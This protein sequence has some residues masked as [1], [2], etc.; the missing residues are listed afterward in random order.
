VDYPGIPE[1]DRSKKNSVTKNVK[2][3]KEAPS[4]QPS[5]S[6]QSSVDPRSHLAYPLSYIRVSYHVPFECL[7]LNNVETD[8]R[9]AGFPSDEESLRLLRV[10]VAS[11]HSAMDPAYHAF[12]TELSDI[13][14]YGMPVVR[15]AIQAVLFLD[16]SLEDGPRGANV[17]NIEVRD[18]TRYLGSK[19]LLTVEGLSSLFFV[20]NMI[21]RGLPPNVRFSVV[22]VMSK[23]EEAGG[24]LDPP[25]EVVVDDDYDLT[26][27]EPEKKGLFS[28]L[29]KFFS[30]ESEKD[31]RIDPSV[32]HCVQFYRWY[33]YH[34]AR[35]SA[36]EVLFILKHLHELHGDVYL[37]DIKYFVTHTTRNA[38]TE[39]MCE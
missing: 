24:N 14:T 29:K 26:N 28:Y 15:N 13:S 37:E 38:T 36:I 9:L 8:V 35:Y 7:Y 12:M 11:Q 27:S 3:S 30:Y 10:P 19:P 17:R 1:V 18:H 31:Y 33:L 25:Q 32:P 21:R 22:P 23:Y 39:N 4:S 20:L 16:F 2:E 34:S 6:A 5:S